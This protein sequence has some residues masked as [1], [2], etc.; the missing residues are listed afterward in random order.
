MHEP[1]SNILPLETP[2]NNT[3]HHTRNPL[4]PNHRN[5]RRHPALPLPKLSRLPSSSKGR[6]KRRAE[7]KPPED[8]RGVHVHGAGHVED[9]VVWHEEPGVGHGGLED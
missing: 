9:V 8:T 7:R 4:N 2:G 5:I 6:E 1:C 3:N